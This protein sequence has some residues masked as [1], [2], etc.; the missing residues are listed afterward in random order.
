MHRKVIHV[1]I[2]IIVF[3]HFSLF[4]EEES[5]EEPSEG[6]VTYIVFQISYVLNEWTAHCRLRELTYVALKRYPG[7]QR[8]FTRDFRFRSS[9]KK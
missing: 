3:Y 6:T 2:I 4:Q 7:C 8:L 9:L 5:E 1:I